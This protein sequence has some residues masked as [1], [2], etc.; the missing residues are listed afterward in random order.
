[1]REYKNVRNISRRSHRQIMPSFIRPASLIMFWF[2]GGSKTSCTSASSTP[3]TD[4]QRF[5]Q[6]F[7]RRSVFS[8][9]RTDR[10]LLKIVRAKVNYVP[11]DFLP[12]INGPR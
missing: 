3:S 8:V 12:D 9:A 6:S 10:A 5:S 11:N 7:F 4:E 2:Q 1:M